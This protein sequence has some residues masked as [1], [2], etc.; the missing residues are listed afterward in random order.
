[1]KAARTLTV[2]LGAQQKLVDERLATGTYASASEIVRAGLRALEREEAA[3]DEI[4]RVKVLEALG[5]PRPPLRAQDVFERLER[6]QAR[7]GEA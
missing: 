4:V 3:L 7:R 6:R 5:D 2:S 1:M